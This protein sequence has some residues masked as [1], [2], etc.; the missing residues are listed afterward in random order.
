MK[1][2]FILGLAFFFAM[3]LNAQVIDI[4]DPVFKSAL[5]SGNYTYD[6][7]D[8]LISLDSNGN[9]EIEQAEALLAYKITV[10]GFL[11]NGTDIVS[12]EGVEYFENLVTFNA[13]DNAITS[14]DLSMLPNLKFVSLSNN[15]LTSLN[16]TGLDQLE[17]LGVLN[18]PLTSLDLTG[19]TALTYL[20]VNSTQLTQLDLSATP[21]LESIYFS[22]STIQTLDVSGLA[23][24]ETVW[25]SDC[26]LTSITFGGNDSL[27]LIFLNDNQ[28]TSI[29][30]SGCPALDELWL[31]NNFLTDLDL[32]G[33][34]MGLSNTNAQNNQLVSISFKNG[35]GD[36]GSAVHFEQNPGLQ[37]A[38]CDEFEQYQLNQ[39]LNLFG[40]FSTIR[41]IYC[42][43]DPG[44]YNYIMDGVILF[45]P[46]GNCSFAGNGIPYQKYQAVTANSTSANYFTNSGGSYRIPF[47]AGTASITPVLETPAFFTVSPETVETEFPQQQSPFTQNFCVAPN[48][49]HTDVEVSIF[50]LDVARPGESSKYRVI[51]RNKGSVNASGTVSVAFDGSLSEFISADMPPLS[52]EPS[53]LTWDFATLLPFESRNITFTLVHAVPPTVNMG[54]MLHFTVHSTTVATD[55]FPS[56]D[57]AEMDQAVLASLDPNDK[58]CVEGNIVGP[59]VIGNYVHY[60][61]RFEN[62]GTFAAENIVVADYIDPNKFDVST[63]QPLD[64]SFPFI[65]RITEGNVEFIFTDINLPYEG[66]WRYGFVAFK[67][68]TLPTLQ[69]GDTFSNTANIYF[70]YNAAVVTDPATTLIQSLSVSD[71]AFAAHFALYPNPAE[72]ILNIKSN[73]ATINSVEVYNML[74]QLVLTA[75]HAD[76]IDVEGLETG[77]YLLRLHS[78]KGVSTTKFT[79]K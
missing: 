77:N 27:D 37:Y 72:T 60:I 70:D 19:V 40:N 18:N 28:L 5:L 31:N 20:N 44:A 42:T 66:D 55:E 6:E 59:E 73:G 11:L 49:S 15:Q 35:V 45:N 71:M 32:S 38:C 79:K 29:D 34:T 8:S 36:I 33:Q 17:R 56:D 25:G 65:T 63:L 2:N 52:A 68:K 14:A 16:V 30:L 69:V 61:I 4:P 67:V 12:V 76:T 1:P 57:T 75:I 9:Q 53:L 7:T 47:P 58:V 3:T 21:H 23:A 13:S 48:G 26:G 74:G 41:T 43:T 22:L 39:K 51:Y 54:D 46:T 24:L 62:T 64:G 78:D 10:D 50:P